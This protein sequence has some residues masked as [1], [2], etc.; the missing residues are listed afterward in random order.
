[1]NGDMVA[2]NG[3]NEESS[4]SSS[5]SSLSDEDNEESPHPK[6]QKLETMESLSPSRS[7][8]QERTEPSPTESVDDSEN[9]NREDQ[10][11]IVEKMDY[12]EKDEQDDSIDDSSLETCKLESDSSSNIEPEQPME[13]G[14]VPEQINIQEPENSSKSPN[15]E[16]GTTQNGDEA[17]GF[18]AV[19]EDSKSTEVS[20]SEAESSED[21][22]LDR[23]GTESTADQETP[24]EVV[25][26][27]V[28]DPRGSPD[29]AVD[30]GRDEAD[31]ESQ[32]VIFYSLIVFKF[33]RYE[34]V[35]YFF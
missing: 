19:L 25:S 2:S 22:N 30:V 20:G 12:V 5:S 24:H 26:H 28:E 4:S 29:S 21:S 18:E 27:T 3:T 1:M 9:L 35:S 34:F 13:S 23:W 33:T 14:E 15:Q 11:S 8:L 7:L 6:R 16:V 17:C 32:Q 10:G 31:S